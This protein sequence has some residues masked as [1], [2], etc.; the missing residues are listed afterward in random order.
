MAAGSLVYFIDDRR[1]TSSRVERGS[2]PPS[3][4]PPPPKG[5]RGV[6][7]LGVWGVSA[8]LPFIRPP[9]PARPRA[10]K[11]E[12]LLFMSSQAYRSMTEQQMYDVLHHVA[13]TPR[14]LSPTHHAEP[15]LP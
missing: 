9:P 7:H 11:D 6:S 4:V 2:S 1:C 12:R 13:R 10:P 8:P 3:R 15:L 14:R 5:R